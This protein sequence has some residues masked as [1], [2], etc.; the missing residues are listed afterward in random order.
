[1]E[2][3]R[4]LLEAGSNPNLLTSSG[5]PMLF[6]PVLLSIEVVR[7][8][9]EHGYEMTA[10]DAKGKS[11][12]AQAVRRGDSEVVRYVLDHTA[13]VNSPDHSGSTPL[14]A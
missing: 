14:H 9:H 6:I 4:I 8:F 2:I 3:A 12:L 11:L 5:S 13:D 7:L 1:M 10:R